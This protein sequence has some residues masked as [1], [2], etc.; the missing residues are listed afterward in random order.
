[1]RDGETKAIRELK[2]GHTTSNVK[3]IMHPMR[4]LHMY[5]PYQVK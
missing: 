4:I 3:E 1:M 2:G 5:K